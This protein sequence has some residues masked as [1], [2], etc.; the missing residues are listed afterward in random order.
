MGEAARV[1][2]RGAV[3]IPAKI[4]RQFGIEEGTTVLVDSSPKGVLIRPAVTLP[5]EVYSPERKASFILGSLAQGRGLSQAARPGPTMEPHRRLALST[6]GGPRPR[7]GCPTPR[8]RDTGGVGACRNG[9]CKSA[10]ARIERPPSQGFSATTLP[11][12]QT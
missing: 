5:V 1:G 12:F 4:R 2:K 9:D 11:S 8:L 3:V 6:L 7:R 10:I